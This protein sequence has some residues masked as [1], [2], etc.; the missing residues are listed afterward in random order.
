MNVG[1]I[2]LGR[3]LFADAAA[4]VPDEDMIVVITAI[5]RQN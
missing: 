3:A 4:T 2:G 1:V 5:A